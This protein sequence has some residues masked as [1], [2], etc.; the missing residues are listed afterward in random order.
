MLKSELSISRSVPLVMD[1]VSF[2][3]ECESLKDALIFLVHKYFL[4]S[5]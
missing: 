4:A 5:L 1:I 3:L 2:L